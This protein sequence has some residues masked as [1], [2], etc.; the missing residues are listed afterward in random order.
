MASKKVPPEDVMRNLST[1]KKEKRINLEVTD[2]PINTVSIQRKKRKS[3][4]SD[5]RPDRRPDHPKP[6]A[7]LPG[8]IY[9]V[10]LEEVADTRTKSDSLQ[11][12]KKDSSSSDDEEKKLPKGHYISKAAPRR[13][14]TRPDHP[15]APAN[16]RGARINRR[17]NSRSPVA[18]PD[19]PQAPANV[20]GPRI[21]RRLNSRTAP[22]PKRPAAVAAA[23]PPS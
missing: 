18:R 4:S 21:N 10:T 9:R 22:A 20:R 7:K 14:D 16:V 12:K 6:H 3:C 23:S 2:I 5:A 1:R 8:P 11:R 17:R 19:H 15:Q 13:P